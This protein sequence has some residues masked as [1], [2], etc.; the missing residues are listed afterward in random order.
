MILDKISKE[1][2]EQSQF[3]LDNRQ[4]REWA[5]NYIKRKYPGNYAVDVAEDAVIS[6]TFDTS[7]D[8]T[9]FILKYS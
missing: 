8:L 1:V 7:E 2:I 6:M 9:L 5:I 4:G 3:M